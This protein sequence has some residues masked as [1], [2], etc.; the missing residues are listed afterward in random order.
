MFG[1]PKTFVDFKI[2][3]V[4]LFGTCRINGVKNNN[5]LNNIVNFPHST[6]E[7]LQQI[8]FLNG[9]LSIPPPFDRLCFRTGIVDNKSISYN[10]EFTRLFNEST[11]CILEIC[12]AKLYKYGGFYLHHLCVDQRFSHLSHTPRVILD[13]FICSKQ[14]NEEIESDI[15][16]IKELLGTRRMIVVTHYNSKMGDKIIEARDNLITLLT[17]ICQR[18]DIP[19]IKP[20]DVL[21]D[22]PQDL[23][24]EPD[25]GHYTPF[26]LDKF[27]DYINEYITKQST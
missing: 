19:I 20:S 1:N 17:E 10:S 21:K 11:V 27:S 23:V 6:K 3:S 14:T 18:H 8:K 13:N 2:M 5:N 22:C 26:G 7:I 12:S 25:L 4:T 15:L 16:E 24:M 9:T